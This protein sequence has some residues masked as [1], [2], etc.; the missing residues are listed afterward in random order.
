M[1]EQLDKARLLIVEDDDRLAE[2]LLE[3]LGMHGFELS[4]VASGDAGAERIVAAQP[5][6]VI[7]DLMLPGSSGL[8]VCR[9]VRERYAGAILMLT[10]SQSEADHV[11]GLE[12]GADDFVIK[13]VEPRVLLARIRAQLRRRNRD[14]D[15]DADDG[16]AI[17]VGTL[18]LDLA[19]RGAT[20]EGQ[21][22]PLTAMEFDVL[23][24]LA[25]GAGS[26]IK[27]EDLYSRVL[28]VEY[29]GLDRGLDVHISRIRRKFQRVGFDPNRLKSVRGVGYLLVTR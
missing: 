23:S 18:R 17:E 27:R 5:D 26:V 4:R 10:A 25:K 14:R 20:V 8:E 3:Y 2:L 29:D 12:L 7:L 9:Q 6:L 19:R 11:A 1:A 16:E 22:L 28:G 24:M 15:L 13:P 21:P